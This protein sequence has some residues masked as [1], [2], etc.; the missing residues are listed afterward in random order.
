[1]TDITYKRGVIYVDDH[2]IGLIEIVRVA[3]F[4][5]L[6]AIAFSL[7]QLSITE[8]QKLIEARCGNIFEQPLQ[9]QPKPSVTPTPQDTNRSEPMNISISNGYIRTD[10]DRKTTETVITTQHTA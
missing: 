1:M 2:E 7:G 9:P 10:H 3:A 4:F 8:Q 5:I 6:I